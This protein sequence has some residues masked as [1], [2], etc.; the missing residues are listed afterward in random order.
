MPFKF[1]QNP[2]LQ[3]VLT[4]NEY[5][6]TCEDCGGTG[7]NPEY[8]ELNSTLFEIQKKWP[9]DEKDIFIENCKKCHGDGYIYWTENA[10]EKRWRD[11]KRYISGGIRHTSVHFLYSCLFGDTE[12][13][14]HYLWY[15]NTLERYSLHLSL[16]EY[17]KSLKYFSMYVPLVEK[18]ILDVDKETFEMQIKEALISYGFVCA[19]CFFINSDEFQERGYNEFYLVRPKIGEKIQGKFSNLECRSYFMLCERCKNKLTPNEINTILSKMYIDKFSNII[20]PEYWEIFYENIKMKI[21][22]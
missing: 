17:I 14:S 11:C 9:R 2:N 20:S 21:F 4:A 10:T 5:L 19:N 12:F 1:P 16:F 7:S 22:Y 13:V 6:E 18:Y 15:D 8:D 3:N